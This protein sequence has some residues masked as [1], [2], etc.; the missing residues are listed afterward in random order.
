MFDGL[1][2]DVRHTA[3]S[4]RRS[5]GFAT[6]VVATLTLAIG[7]NT[8]LF[9]V[10]NGLVL[11]TLPVREPRRLVVLT[12]TSQ[13]LTGAQ[14]IYSATLDRLRSAQGVFS[15][16]TL[17][18]GGGA[19]RVEARGLEIDGGIEG[20]EPAYFE[21]LGARPQIGR[22]LQPADAVGPTGAPVVV[23]SDRLWRRLFAR[24]PRAVGEQIRVNAVPLTVVGV[25][26]PSFR[27]LQTDVGADLFMTG[28][29]L[30]PISGD[31]TRPPRGR[32]AIAQLR[33]GVTVDEARAA[34]QAMWPTVRA[35]E[36]PGLPATERDTIATQQITV[37]SIATGFSPLRDQ[38]GDALTMLIALTGVLLAIG[39]A[40]LSGLLLART[41]ARDHDTTVRLALGASRARLV[42][43]RLIETIALALL[44]AI[45]AAPLAW[46]TSRVLER[47]LTAGAFLPTMVSMTPDVRVF[48]AA[49]L[50][51]A[52]T[53]ALV[54]VLPAWHSARMRT[55]LGEG[56]RTTAVTS[57]AGRL[58]LVGQ[59]A[60]SLV[61][62]VGASL[63]ARSM[64]HLREGE[65]RYEPTEIVWT[66]LWAKAAERRTTLSDPAA[67]WTDLAQRFAA[68]PGVASIAY[69]NNFPVFFAAGFGI[70]RFD[71]ADAASPGA[72]EALLDGVS[73]GFFHTLGVPLLRGRD[74]AW[75]D[76][77]N[78][79]PVAIVTDAFARTL[80]PNGDALGRRVRV[81]TRQPPQTFEIVGIAA[82]APYRRLD[83][84]HQPAVFRAFTQDA[85]QVQQPI[86][87][88][89]TGRNAAPVVDAFWNMVPSSSRHFVRSVSRLDDYVDE[90]RFRKL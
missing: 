49:T 16:M 85:V 33:R 70:E 59:I 34:V 58:L 71:V 62:V 46:W 4:I 23:I 60:L 66:R 15:A 63:F 5:P 40:N 67:Y 11:K 39:C 53:G 76:T 82:D 61:L 36:I 13:R 1:W 6:I 7:A 35:A 3:R 51:A 21:M 45:A 75:T 2:Q 83:E 27:G 29:R 25:T 32:N 54:G 20:V 37:T 69:A 79:P 73:P 47:A 30:R 41:V 77:R 28:A 52:A 12:P 84:P 68:L 42:Q 89:R 80:F 43:Q 17:Y 74:V 55:A 64:N 88:V 19:L 9:S 18:S 90:I 81:V 22:L 14:M 31:M 24:D 8:A 86:M 57:M 65:A 26:E 87:L 44:G 48:A 78:S 50:M 56:V 72:V 38:Y 10:F